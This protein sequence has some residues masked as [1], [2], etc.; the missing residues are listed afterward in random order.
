[1]VTASQLCKTY[2]IIETKIEALKDVNLTVEKNQFTSISGP[3]GSGKTTLLN[4]ISSIDKP[5]SG[6]ITVFENDLGAKNEDFLASFRCHNIG[7]VFQS[8]NLVSTLTVAENI[9]FPLEWLETPANQIKKRI[10]ELLELVD[11]QQRRNHFPFQLSGGEQQRVAFARALANNPPL[12]LADEPTGNLDT[13]TGGKIIQILQKLKDEGKTIIIATHDNQI[14]S[15]A[16]QRFYLEDGK[17]ANLN[18]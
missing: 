14:L 12:L 11:L 10:E 3:S 17:L 15:L 16:D 6:R 18:E 7:F 8:Y 1:M 4:I 2:Q 5:T 9:A 13:K